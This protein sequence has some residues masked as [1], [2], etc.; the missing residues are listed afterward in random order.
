MISLMPHAADYPAI[1][2]LV[3]AIDVPDDLDNL[4]SNT[5]FFVRLHDGRSF[6]FVAITPENL[7]FLMDRDREKSYLIPGMVIVSAITIDCVLD[8]VEHWLPPSEADAGLIG[9]FGILQICLDVD[10]V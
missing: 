1:L 2:R 9:E 10:F 3:A 6:L 7:R 4:D 5:D 8:A